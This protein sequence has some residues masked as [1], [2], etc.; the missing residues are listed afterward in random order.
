LP[1][2]LAQPPRQDINQRRARQPAPGAAGPSAGPARDPSASEGINGVHVQP[3]LDG[4]SD[5]EEL[6]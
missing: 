5:L 6:E 1:D 3:V 4:Y 2:P